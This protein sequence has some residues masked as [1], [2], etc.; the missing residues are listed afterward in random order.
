MYNK[1]GY[2]FIFAFLWACSPAEKAQQTKPVAEVELSEKEEVA[3]GNAYMEGAKAKVLGNY[4]TAKGH[5]KSALSINSQSAAAHYELGLV[6]NQLDELN[7]AFQEFEMASSIDPNN[8]WYKLSYAG[9]LE[10]QGQGEKA[11]KVFKELVEMKPT[12]IELKYELSK[13][14]LQQKKFKESIAYLNEIEGEVGV[15]EEITFL[16][17]RIHLAN[18]DVDAAAE[19]LK[20][21]IE[22]K[23]N[24]I[25]YYGVLAD[26]YMSNEKKKEAFK[27]YQKMEEL[28]PDNYLVQFSLA[29]YY[30][31]EGEREKYL[32]ALQ[33]AFTSPEMSI[34]DKVKYILSFYQ[35][36]SKDSARKAEGIALCRIIVKAH[37][38]NAKSHALLADFL[39]FDNQLEAAKQQYF[40]TIVLDSSRFPVWNQ[41][42][43]ILSETNDQEN[44]LNYGQ[45]A[46][47]LFPNQ[48]T[49]YLL[50]ALGLSSTER[51]EEAIEYLEMGKDL[52]LDNRGLKSQ[53]YSSIGDAYH[54]TGNH[55]KSDENFELALELDPNNVYVLNN[56]SYY[57]SLRKDSL[58]KAKLMSKRTID[59]APGQSSF[60]DTYAWI[61][62]QLKEYEAA[63]EWIDKALK[64]DGSRS[65]V[66]LEHKGDIL[67]RLGQKENAINY[68]KK[69]QAAG[70]ASDQIDEKVA[71]GKIDE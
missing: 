24:E 27:V 6:H 30:R 50:Y 28:E 14:L 23:P 32:N 40:E 35:V 41:L 19:E 49:V 61:L 34:D 3:F 11:I 12:Q 62:Y 51:H 44:L 38:K 42:L 48:P 68:W 22:S 64:A 1:L 36:D 17:Q 66:L 63:N 37:P 20:K 8:Y 60:L 43:I 57:L 21:L 53:I 18:D 15:N 46:V 7:E 13:L 54:E 70:G 55:A 31:S 26:I 9:F 47:N 4:E 33:N 69:A 71:E 10:S 65:G 56:Y 59:L 29:E 39:Y 16:K 2:L 52:V 67:F 45:R 25:R 5:F 58:E